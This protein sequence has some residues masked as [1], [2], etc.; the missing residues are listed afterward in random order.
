MFGTNEKTTAS[1]K[2]NFNNNKTDS[3]T[4]TISKTTS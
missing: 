2:T 4:E 1:S 3:A